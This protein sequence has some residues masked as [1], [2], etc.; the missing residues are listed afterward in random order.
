MAVSLSR[1]GTTLMN[2]IALYARVSTAQQEQQGTIQSQLAA[3]T[4][5]ATA[6]GWKIAPEHMY[7]DDGYSS[8][9]LDRPGLELLPFPTRRSSATPAPTTCPWVKLRS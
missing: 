8:A 2:A 4:A 1:G 9:R 5:Y 7:T 6:H 3:L